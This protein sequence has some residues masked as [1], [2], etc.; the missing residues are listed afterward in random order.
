MTDSNLYQTI[1]PT[2]L[3]EWSK[4]Q[5]AFYLIH[6]LSA[7]HFHRV[8]LPRA[9]QACVFEVTFVDQ[10][11]ALVADKGDC[12]VLYGSSRRCADATTAAEKLAQAGYTQLFVFSGGIAAWRSAGLPLEGAAADDPANPNTRLE[13]TDR[14]FK[15][16]PDQSSIQWTGRNPGT[17]HW[18]N[19]R[20][21]GGTLDVKDGR[22]GGHFDI[23]MRSITSINLEGDELAPVLVAH[24]ES[25]DFFLTKRF[26]RATFSITRTTPKAEPWLSAPNF[27]IQGDLELR[28]IKAPLEF[29][30]TVTPT[31]TSGLAAEAHFDIDRTRWGIIYGSTRFFDHLGMH[32][33]FDL[34]S[35]QI[36]I[37]AH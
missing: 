36:R 2:E 9:I 21:A 29:T 28:G 17:T 13:L 16:D 25:D 23:D 4:T 14:S 6:T 34:I 31:V 22:M 18:G 37:V 35:F 11:A 20:L 12:I 27:E 7:D 30:T 26:P 8:H 32:L 1:S 3:N 5:K 10:V 19:I 15:V 24:L 33:I